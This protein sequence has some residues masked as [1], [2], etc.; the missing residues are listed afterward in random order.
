MYRATRECKKK[1]TLS[2]G[3]IIRLSASAALDVDADIG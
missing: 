1:E 3:P 2:V